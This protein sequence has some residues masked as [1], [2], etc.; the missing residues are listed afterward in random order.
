MRTC[1][2][3]WVSASSLRPSAPLRSPGA[4]FRRAQPPPPLPPTMPS[5]RDAALLRACAAG[6]LMLT[7]VALLQSDASVHAMFGI[8]AATFEDQIREP[9][10]GR[11]AEFGMPCEWPHPPLLL[12]YDLR[13]HRRADSSRSRPPFSPWRHPCSWVY[14]VRASSTLMTALGRGARW[15]LLPG[16]P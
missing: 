6:W 8:A 1:L 5:D 12:L 3:A 14:R 7:P 11:R 9:A 10:V 15:S 2:I 16:C 4:L 13:P